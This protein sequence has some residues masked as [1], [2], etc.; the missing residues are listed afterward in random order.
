ME[1]DDETGLILRLLNVTE[2]MSITAVHRSTGITTSI[3]RD[4]RRGV[5]TR[6][7]RRTR[8]KIEAHLTRAHHHSGVRVW[9]VGSGSSKSTASKIIRGRELV[10]RARQL[11]DP[12]ELSPVAPLPEPSVARNR[13]KVGCP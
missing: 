13:H 2:G 1:N 9:E 8:E 11:V 12:A 4:W 6:L 10:E 3:I 7:T 5:Y